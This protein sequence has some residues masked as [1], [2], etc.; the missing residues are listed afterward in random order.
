MGQIWGDIIS[1]SFGGAAAG[2][3]LYVVQQLHSQYKDWRDGER[4]YV[5]LVEQSGPAYMQSFSTTRRIAS[6]TNLT[7]DRVRYLC[8]QH[9]KIFFTPLADKDEW[10]IDKTLVDMLELLPD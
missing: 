6:Y 8:S 1:T 4:V 7:E 10:T 3:A 2:I 5:W 9:T